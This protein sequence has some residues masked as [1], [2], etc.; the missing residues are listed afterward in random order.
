[1]TMQILE[2]VHE[3]P[4]KKETGYVMSVLTADDRGREAQGTYSVRL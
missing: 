4:L 3:T 1:M 2:H